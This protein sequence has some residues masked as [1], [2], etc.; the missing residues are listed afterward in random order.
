MYRQDNPPSP[1]E[2]PEDLM[3]LE[4]HFD[5]APLLHN[6]DKKKRV[7]LKD[8][9]I[10]FEA[11]NSTSNGLTGSNEEILQKFFAIRETVLPHGNMYH[12]VQTKTEKDDKKFVI[13]ADGEVCK[14]GCTESKL[15]KWCARCNDREKLRRKEELQERNNARLIETK[16]DSS[17]NSMEL[18][19]GGES[20][21]ATNTLTSKLEALHIDNSNSNESRSLGVLSLEELKS[22]VQTLNVYDVLYEHVYAEGICFTVADVVVFVYTYFLLVSI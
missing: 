17:D 13:S 14:Y 3:K 12:R 21:S 8:V 20:I 22:Y 19:K 11:Q 18:V 15:M 2:I 16:T 7:L 5:K 10:E 6:D 1:V 4:L 9:I